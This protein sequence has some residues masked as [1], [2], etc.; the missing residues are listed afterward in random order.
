[1]VPPVASTVLAAAPSAAWAW[2]NSRQR[3]SVLQNVPVIR[4][5]LSTIGRVHIAES[6]LFR[7]VG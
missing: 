4:L 3:T 2:G 6:D 7:T 1:M 5:E